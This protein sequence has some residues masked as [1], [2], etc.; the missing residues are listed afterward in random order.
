MSLFDVGDLPKADTCSAA[1]SAYS[2]IS[3]AQPRHREVD[4]G[5]RRGLGGSFEEMAGAV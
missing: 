4:S 3:S 2:I 1:N 5:P